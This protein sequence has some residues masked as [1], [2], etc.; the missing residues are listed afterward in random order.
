MQPIE[1]TDEELTYPKKAQRKRG[2]NEAEQEQSKHRKR[3]PPP[4]ETT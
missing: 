4:S 3:P 1:M 2:T